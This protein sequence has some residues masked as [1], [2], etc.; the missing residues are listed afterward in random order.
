MTEPM[1]AET[2]TDE[3]DVVIY[4]TAWCPYC[5]RAK[6]LLRRKSIDFHEIDVTFSPAKRHEMSVRAQGRTTVPQIFIKGRPIGGSDE[7]VAL[8]AQGR[9]DQLLGK[10]A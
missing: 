10:A 4:T 8:D 6:T 3:P 5:H 2:E 1:T 7:L 9:L